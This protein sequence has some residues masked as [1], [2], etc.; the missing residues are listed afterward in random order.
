ME[1]FSALGRRHKPDRWLFVLTVLLL[2]IGMVVVYSISP[3]L[4]ASENISQNYFI[5]KQ[6]IEVILGIAA[7]G[8]AAYLPLS[9][10]LKIVTPLAVLAIAG[11]FIVMLTP[12]NEVYQ[13][14]RWIRLGGFSFQIAELIKLALILWLARFLA[15]RQ[16]AGKLPDLR[17]VLQPLL[18]LLV[19][20]G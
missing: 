2:T 15:A 16:R 4:A 10:W 3:G 1:P 14:H 12:L 5:T 17:S 11:S 9:K 6:F 13:A 8:I 18:I 7:F 20:I 19:V